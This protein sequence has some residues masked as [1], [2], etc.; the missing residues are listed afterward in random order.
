MAVEKS[1]I[2]VSVIMSVYNGEKYL[3]EAIESILCQSYRNFEFI[4]VNDG[5]VDNTELIIKEYNDDR[6]KLLNKANGGLA[7]SLNAGI[8][9]STSEYLVRMD[10]DDVSFPERIE[11]QLKYMLNNPECVMTGSD[12]Y[13]IDQNGNYLYTSDLPESDEEIGKVLKFTSPFFH[14]SVMMKRSA[15]IK[16]GGYFE[17]V[18]QHVEDY[19]LFNKIKQFGFLHNIKRPLIKYR[20][21]PEGLANRANRTTK[22]MIT[23][24]QKLV[25][26]KT[27]S[28]E[29]MEIFTRIR[30]KSERKLLGD[31]YCRI[32]CICL[33]KKSDKILARQKFVSALKKYP[34]NISFYFFLLLSF[35]PPYAISGWRKIRNRN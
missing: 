32:G 28:A 10:A 2:I 30:K 4:I 29:E 16:C 1:N 8:T 12:G 24:A 27:V 34:F 26:E 18:K 23:V 22:K 31:Y 6:I 14:S 17:P 7:Q 35:L 9:I 5:S 13:F 11:I 21:V 20:L 33:Y 19:I 25:E 15:V 3:K